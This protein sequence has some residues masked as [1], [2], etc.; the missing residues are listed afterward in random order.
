MT[1]KRLYN[2]P[3][4]TTR[5]GNIFYVNFRLLSGAFFRQSLG[6]DSLKVAEVTMSRLMPYIPLVQSGAMSEEAFKNEIAGVRKASKR[7]VDQFL[8]HWLSMNAE[9]PWV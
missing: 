8:V 7:D 9:S 2:N 1:N 5:R 3:K 6:T 4:F